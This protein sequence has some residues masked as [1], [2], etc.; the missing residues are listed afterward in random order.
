MPPKVRGR[1]RGAS[2][3]SR[4]SA[5]RLTVEP[6][7]VRAML[8]KTAAATPAAMRDNQAYV[9]HLMGTGRL[10]SPQE[11][12]LERQLVAGLDQGVPR[13]RVVLKLLRSVPASTVHVQATY[14]ALLGRAPSPRELRAGIELVRRFGDDRALEVALLGT[15][16]FYTSRGGGTDAGF[17]GALYG[18]ILHRSPTATEQASGLRA[19]AGPASRPGLASRLLKLPEAQAIL[20]GSAHRAAGAAAL[21]ASPQD[22]QDL[23][24]PGGLLKVTARALA[25]DAAFL[26]I[27][28]PTPTAPAA[29]ASASSQPPG[30]PVA[31]GFNLNSSVQ[32]LALSSDYI[33]AYN[34]M[35]AGEDDVLWIAVGSGLSTYDLN[36][37][38]PTQV[39]STPG[40]EGTRLVSVAAIDATEAYAVTDE[41]ATI[42]HVLVSGGIGTATTLPVLPG[43]DQATQVA[44]SPDGTVWVLAQSGHLYSYASAS[45]SWT[46]IATGGNLLEQISVG[47]ASNIYA[48]T[49]AGVPLQYSASTGFQA[50][51]FFS[52]SAVN[53]IQATS[54]GS[55]WAYAKG[56]LFMKPSYGA[57]M[58]VP[59]AAEP[60]GLSPIVGFNTPVFA[61]GSMNRAYLLGTTSTSDPYT[62]LQIDLINFGVVDRQPIPFPSYQGNELAAYNALSLA[63]TLNFNDDIR[64]LYNQTGEP[65]SSFLANL[66]T[67]KTPP[68]TYDPTAW[69]IVFSELQTELT[70]VSAV[71]ARLDAIQ[72]TNGQIQT[73]NDGQLTSV[74]QTAGLIVNNTPSPS[75]IDVVLTD[76]FEGVLG[77]ISST[78]IGAGYATLAALLSAGVSDAIAA[79]QQSK[80][81][82]PND[83]VPI[84]FSNLQTQL[85]NIFAATISTISTIN[86]DLAS[87]ATDSGKLAAV[88]GK[89]LSN[90]W[91][92]PDTANIV[93]PTTF[94]YDV[95]FYQ[96]LTA[97]KWQVEH[98]LYGDYNQYPISQIFGSIPAYDYAQYPDGY[99]DGMEV[100]NVYLINQLGSTTD[101]NS[102]D[103]QDGNFPSSAL[104]AGVQGL[105]DANTDAFWTGQGNWS[106]IKRLEAT[107]G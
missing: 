83:A 74:G 22:Y 93:T 35:S 100:E 95:Y 2:R 27:A 69:G 44:A 7:E 62:S 1:Y 26:R 15:R 98:S 85:D 106:V 14:T 103:L 51:P 65:W 71:Y 25:D 37:G 78:G 52:G 58:S 32:P 61:A 84:E 19:L 20:A 102:P 54:D 34:A 49:T 88:A 47:S 87:I 70:E 23:A 82:G 5:A 30:Y 72:V 91:P 11:S 13:E 80:N 9:A 56:F 42:I 46:P 104:I 29:G 16:E 59:R 40:T 89:I 64:T 101:W 38:I 36:S 18:S 10:L 105:G 86:A 3:V 55:D 8:S 67:A 66:D 45:Q 73:I 57:W 63:A 43:G 12:A 28:N 99:E 48:L 50:D 79:F 53:S 81:L 24:R 4:P 90:A 60:T 41:T 96:S 39:Y 107:L 68:P 97:S 21:G 94:A 75:Y 92:F 17:L 31:D 6:L 77:A 33:D 76:L